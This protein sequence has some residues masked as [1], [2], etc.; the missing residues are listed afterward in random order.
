MAEQQFQSI[1]LE[2]DFKIDSPE[3]L[4]DALSLGRSDFVSPEMLNTS[5]AQYLSVWRQQPRLLPKNETV[6]GTS[7]IF[8][9]PSA[10]DENK[11]V[12]AAFFG[13]EVLF[14]VTVRPPTPKAN[15][16]GL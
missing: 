4:T 2:L 1:V 11:L 13:T 8:R 3:R 15:V 12:G 7:Y 14:N 5:L 10:L 16:P 9:K 6:H